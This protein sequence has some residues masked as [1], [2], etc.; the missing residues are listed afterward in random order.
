VTSAAHQRD[1]LGHLSEFAVRDGTGALNAFQLRRAVGGELLDLVETREQL[2]LF[3]VI[4][5]EIGLVA[6]EQEAALAGLGVE[7]VAEEALAAFA[8]VDRA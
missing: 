5:F 8:D 2:R 7:Q 4:G 6:G 3:V 1:R